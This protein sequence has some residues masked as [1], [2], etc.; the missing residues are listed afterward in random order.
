MAASAPFAIDPQLTAIALAYKNRALIA[1]EVLPRILPVNK[2]TFKY[3]LF[4]KVETMT[5]PDTRVGR[6]GAPTVV[7]FGGTTQTSEALDYGLE[8]EIPFDDQNQAAVDIAQ[9]GNPALTDPVSRATEFL[10]Q[11]VALDREV[12]VANL[13]FNAA[14]YP[15]GS[16]A[17]LAGTSQWSDQANSDPVAT[18]L[19]ALEGCLVRPNMA[20]FSGPVWQ[21]VRRHPKVVSAVNG[22]TTSA[23][24]VTRQA[25]ADLFELERGVQVGGA[26]YNTAKRG[27]AASLA[28][29]WGKH[30][31][32][33]Y[34][35]PLADNERGI[36]FGMTVP[37]GQKIAGQ[38]PDANIGLR[39][40]TRVRVGETVKELITAA[41]A[42][43]F[44]QNAV[45]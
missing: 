30:A 32:F 8:D 37:Y 23:G 25:F 28:R 34:Q 7:E 43:Y 9:G 35:D 3:T 26:F 38:R 19:D 14:T 2:K 10:T 13:V 21:V 24:A 20:V 36:T 18:I 22:V 11:L 45:A 40:G 1:D 39:G 6:R 29:A 44:F 27:Q 33:I 5:I 31:A 12:R 15:V 16:K 41:D 42:A 4:D 17:T